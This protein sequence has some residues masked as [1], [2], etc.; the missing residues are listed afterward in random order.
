MR[1][2]FQAGKNKRLAIN[3][4]TNEYNDNYCFLGAYHEYIKISVSDYNLIRE[5]YVDNY[6]MVYSENF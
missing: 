4:E 5:K 6:Y 1:F 2:Y 3:T